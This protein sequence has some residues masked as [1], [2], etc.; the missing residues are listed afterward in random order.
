M[1]KINYAKKA[2]LTIFVVAGISYWASCTAQ[3]AFCI[4]S[5]RIETQSQLESKLLE[6][7]KK[8][9]IKD[10]IIIHASL[11]GDEHTTLAHS[12]KIKNKE[13]KIVLTQ[14]CRDED[15]LKHELYH[16]ADGHFEKIDKTKGV[17]HIKYGWLELQAEIYSVTGLKF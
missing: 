5:P 3:S 8:L 2:I 9:K 14:S 6:E 1:N 13:Y 17:G 11:D 16:I 12:E 7:R 15:T 4:N 10:S